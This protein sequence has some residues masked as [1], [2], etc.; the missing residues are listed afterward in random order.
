MKSIDIRSEPAVRLL[1]EFLDM[2]SGGER[3]NAEH[4]AHELYSYLRSP[5]HDLAVYDTVVQYDI[6]EDLPPPLS[7]ER[8]SRWR[9]R[10]REGS[11][12]HPEILSRSSR[13]SS[14]DSEHPSGRHLSRRS[15]RSPLRSYYSDERSHSR[16]RNRRGNLVRSQPDRHEPMSEREQGPSRGYDHDGRHHGETGSG[17]E[18]NPHRQD[19]FHEQLAVT[20]K[21][22]AEVDIATPSTR[23]DD[24]ADAKSNPKSSHSLANAAAVGLRM[25]TCTP[26]G[27]PRSETTL[28]SFPAGLGGPGVSS[29]SSSASDQPSAGLPHGV[30]GLNVTESHTIDEARLRG[31][32]RSCE[33][34]TMSVGVRSHNLQASVHAY[35]NKNSTPSNP[36]PR[37]RGYMAGKSSGS[38]SSCSPHML[39]GSS[40]E[41]T[42]SMK[43]E[44]SPPAIMA[45][46]RARMAKHRQQRAPHSPGLG[47]VQM[48]STEMWEDENSLSAAGISIEHDVLEHTGEDYDTASD[49]SN[50]LTPH[51]PSVNLDLATTDT[52]KS[53]SIVL[54]PFPTEQHKANEQR[55][56]SYQ[57]PSSVNNSQPLDSS[58]QTAVHMD[59]ANDNNE[60]HPPE[61]GVQPQTP[62]ERVA[63]REAIL[64]SQAQLRIRLAAAKKVAASQS[65]T[66]Q[67][68]TLESGSTARSDVTDMTSREELLKIKLAQRRR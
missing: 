54:S 27:L 11:W 18:I 3:V 59:V 36:T 60:N 6:R 20:G 8:I 7:Q 2:D 42:N 47:V 49:V 40:R 66:V 23:N 48:Q 30:N 55:N 34:K 4:F 61:E 1:A 45:R 50:S 37:Q 53:R 10:H 67:E 22:Q 15:S 33:Q 17:G 24:V 35:L 19:R 25:D 9:S 12:S 63:Q 29:S 28:I 38:G 13:S 26:N 51:V 31:T 41:Q 21:T 56:D 16:M 14:Q 46:W 68:S 57:I 65:I 58:I 62:A 32:P 43:T 39:S 5:Y 44:M 64:R 52:P